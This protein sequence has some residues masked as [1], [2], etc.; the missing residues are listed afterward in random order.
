[1]DW[2]GL[3]LASTLLFSLVTVLD[4]RLLVKYFPVATSMSFLVGFIQFGV[5]GITLA[6]V[7]PVIGVPDGATAGIAV[8]SGIVWAI[9]L[10]SFFKGLQMEEVSRATPVSTG[11][12]W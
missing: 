4:R 11:S 6:V 12:S 3:G 7:L 1:M 8:L 2:I 5:A 10:M 9:G